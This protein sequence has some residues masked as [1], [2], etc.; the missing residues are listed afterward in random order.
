MK[1]SI[2]L[3]KFF[4]GL[5]HA[6]TAASKGVSGHGSYPLSLVAPLLVQALRG[7]PMW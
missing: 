3:S 7:N 1:G 5:Y 2:S 6:W 4:D